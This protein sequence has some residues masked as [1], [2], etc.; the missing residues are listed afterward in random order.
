VRAPD[1]DLRATWEALM[2]AASGTRSIAPLLPALRPV[3]V[4]ADRLTLACPSSA[5]VTAPLAAKALSALTL[6]SLG[7]SLQVIVRPDDAI[8]TEPS[9]APGR[10]SAAGVTA[11]PAAVAPAP[12]PAD[13]GVGQSDVPGQDLR[14]HPLVRRVAEALGARIVRVIPRGGGLAESSAP[15]VGMMPGSSGA[16]EGDEP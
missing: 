16:P 15:G 9:G 3:E 5:A 7:R 12:A 4:T 1:A 6:P 13:G 11:A 14:A 2:A 8:E 10:S